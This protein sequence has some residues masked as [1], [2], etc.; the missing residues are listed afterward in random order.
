[1]SAPT[2]INPLPAAH[3]SAGPAL[4]HTQMEAP[5]AAA[6]ESL[7]HPGSVRILDEAQG[8]LQR[9]QEYLDRPGL[10]WSKK[11]IS[12]TFREV[13]TPGGSHKHR[14]GLTCVTRAPA[15]PLGPE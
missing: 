5:R 12:M 7:Y 13:P 4:S 8:L 15:P 2:G 11:G 14:G 1:M 10:E 9:L 3:C 6:N